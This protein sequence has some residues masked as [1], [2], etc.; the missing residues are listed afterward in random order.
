MTIGDLLASITGEK[1]APASPSPTIAT[2]PSDVVP[3]R[4]ASEQL[5]G[6]PTK[7]PRTESLVNRP[8][9][10]DNSP[11]PS[12]HL[13][14]R[15]APSQTNRP[16][17]VSQ[18]SPAAPTSALKKPL[19]TASKDG[20]TVSSAAASRPPLSRPVANK[21]ANADSDSAAKPKKRSFAEIMMRAQANAPIRESFG[22]IQHK[23][24]EKLMTMKERKE[25]KVE[26]ARKAK[27]AGKQQATGKYTGTAAGRGT[28]GRPGQKPGA[29]SAAKGS[30]DKTPPVEEKK[31]KKAALA[32]T[33]Y[34][35][36]AR[37]RPGSTTSKPGSTARP[38]RP[39]DRE[40]PRYG[41]GVS[42]SR[43]YEEEDEFD[44]FI[45]DDE[46]DDPNGYGYGRAREYDSAE[47][48]SDMEAG[49]SDIDEEEQMAE[50]MARRED[51]KEMELE[52]RLK[53]EKEE[54]KRKALA[55]LKSK[56]AAR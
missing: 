22:K 35:G 3:K 31:V 23:P 10:N 19:S 15:P 24:V 49:L 17:S 6:A 45:V 26:E 39:V 14:D 16:T 1:S 55:A 33:G 13:A 32:T 8:R 34:A 40:R 20:R 18:S 5:R 56:T 7:A 36:T 47:D 4:K 43:R 2:R 12:P 38:G 41:G 28:P 21:P 50:R 42:R 27:L 30:K 9:S 11:R 29:A 53:K 48:E 37:P 51:L 25:L 46:D 52:K 44:D 54:R